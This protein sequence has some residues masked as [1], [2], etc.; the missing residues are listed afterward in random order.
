MIPLFISFPGLAG[1]PRRTH[2]RIRT[3]LAPVRLRLHPRPVRCPIN[4]PI[5]RAALSNDKPQPLKEDDS[6]PGQSFPDADRATPKLSLLTAR[7]LLSFVPLLWGSFVICAKLLYTLPVALSPAVFNVMRMFVA[8]S[9][10]LPVL[11]IELRNKRSLWPGIQLGFL[12]CGSNISQMVGLQ[13]GPAARAAFINQ[14]STVLVPLVAAAL[15]IESLTRRV[16]IG[17]FTALAGIFLL[18]SSPS[19]PFSARAN[20]S[21]AVAM[22][23]AKEERPASTLWLADILQ[24]SSAA[25]ETAY[26]LRMTHVTQA[27]PPARLVPLTAVKVTTHAAGTVLWLGGRSMLHHFN[28]PGASTMATTASNPRWP[29]SAVVCNV[30]LVLYTGVMVSAAST[31]FQTKGQSRV[32]AGE[33]ACIFASKPLWSS[34]LAFAIL[35][36]RMHPP[37]VLGAVLIIGGAVLASTGKDSKR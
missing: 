13:Y 32:S 11:I 15:R 25:F 31:I 33:A 36:E 12:V 34:L 5:V 14:L 2:L 3:P 27:L 7:L 8:A 9:L 26:V 35:K 19:L 24:F 23:A 20:T 1:L 30:L 28:N 37:A 22:V 17:S 29:V 4:P 21:S 10:F 16:A 18:T 6:A